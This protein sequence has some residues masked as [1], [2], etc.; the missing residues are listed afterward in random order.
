LK[1]SNLIRVAATAL[2]LSTLSFAAGVAGDLSLADGPTSGTRVV[3]RIP[4][5]LPGDTVRAA[6]LALVSTSAAEAREVPRPRL[7][8][9][10][11]APVDLL[12]KPALELALT[13]LAKENP[14]LAPKAGRRKGG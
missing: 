8:A 12:D 3:L 7:R 6:P 9:A 13:P 2:V 4:P 1:A 5:E 14:A 10:Y 11:F